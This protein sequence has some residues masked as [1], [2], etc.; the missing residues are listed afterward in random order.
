MAINQQITDLPTPPSR[1]DPENFDARADA[2]LASLDN[3]ADE[4]NQW[5]QEANSTADEVNLNTELTTTYKNQTLEARDNAI[6]SAGCGLWKSDI[7]YNTHDRAIGSDGY[8]YLSL[9][10]GNIGN[11]PTTDDGSRWQKIKVIVKEGDPEVPFK[12]APA[13]SADEALARGQIESQGF[14]NLIQNGNFASWSGGTASTPDG[15]KKAGDSSLAQDSTNVKVGPYSLSITYGTV[16]EQ[17]YQDIP[18]WQDYRE[19]TLTFGCWVLTSTPNIARL[20][21]HDATTNIQFSPY[22]TGDGTWQFLTVP[23]TLSSGATLIRPHLLVEGTGTVIYS[24]AVLVKGTLALP[25]QE[26]PLDRALP[27]SADYDSGWFTVS[28]TANNT[29]TLAHGLR[30]I[31][32]LVIVQIK[33]TTYG[34]IYTHIGANGTGDVNTEYQQPL[35]VRY[36][37]T[38]ILLDIYIGQ[39]LVQ[40]WTASADWIQHD[41]HEWRVLA[42]R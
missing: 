16:L 7:T 19:S 28:R 12:V 38:Y 39:Y 40:Y 41:N 21:I 35:T 25:Y 9:I 5:A 36:D 29:V 37:S 11:D 14:I 30:T 17:I 6:A 22:H 32:K 1:S 20:K 27:R 4:V 31:P 24:G 8:T 10:D 42:W 3:F 23:I 18:N 13:T 26:N 2:F 33:D 15:W 34:Y